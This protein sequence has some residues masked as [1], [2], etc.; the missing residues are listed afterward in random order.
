[1]LGKYL[2]TQL[3]TLQA[4]Y[5]SLIQNSRGLGLLCAFDFKTSEL[6]D[7]FKQYC[8]DNK[9]IILGC[10]EKSIRFRPP[11]NV[12]QTGLDEGLNIIEKVLNFMSSIN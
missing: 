7:N 5:S 6:R 12:T 2:L 8:L 10:G 3:H 9:L 11:L 4:K 1:M